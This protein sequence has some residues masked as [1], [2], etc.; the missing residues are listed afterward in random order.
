VKTAF[1]I[2]VGS[3]CLRYVL[4]KVAN[5]LFVSGCIPRYFAFNKFSIESTS[6]N[7]DKAL[8]LEINTVL[9]LFKIN[10]YDYS[11]DSAS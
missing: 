9:L 6:L 3:I 10:P 8:S 7:Y 4:F 2:K 5:C 1:N 11:R